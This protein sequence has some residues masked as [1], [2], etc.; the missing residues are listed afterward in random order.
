MKS[1]EKLIPFDLQKALEGDPVVTRAGRKVKQITLF[2]V[3]N[4]YRVVGVVDGL[5][6]SFQTDGQSSDSKHYDLFMEPKTHIVNGFE[7]P[8][9]VTEPPAKAKIYYV[10][11]LS[12][13]SWCSGTGWDGD[14]I[15]RMRLERNIVFLNKEDAIA[16]AKAMAGI[17]PYGE[18]NE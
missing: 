15:D 10:P 5:I 14:V 7:V 11:N 6:M 18:V 12:V 9:P 3:L 4:P 17:D 13:E 2:N 8:K 1:Q 16:N